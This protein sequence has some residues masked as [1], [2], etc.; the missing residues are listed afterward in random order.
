MFIIIA[1]ILIIVFV[2]LYTRNPRMNYG[3]YPSTLV[4]DDFEKMY[5]T[6]VVISPQSFYEQYFGHNIVKLKT[7]HTRIRENSK[8]VIWLAGDSS[9]DNKHWLF[10]NV[11]EKNILV[12][13]TLTPS[14]VYQHLFVPPI[15]LPDVAACINSLTEKNVALNC[16]LEESS[17]WDRSSKLPDTDRLIRH[18]IEPND[19]LI[20]SVGG[21]DVA[22]KLCLRTVFWMLVMWV[23]PFEWIPPYVYDLFHTQVRDYILKLTERNRPRKIIVCMFYYPCEMGEGWLDGS[24]VFRLYNRNREKMQRLIDLIFEKCTRKIKIPGSEVVPVHL[25]HVLDSRDEKDYVSRIEP[26]AQGGLKMATR[27]VEIIND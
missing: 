9:L 22:L 3:T 6:N 19:T 24:P 17:L 5:D 23:L 7:I 8:N 16:A 25:G 2:V 15:C 20:V 1:I 27:F 21:N 12:S 26:S 4:D 10:N 11:F 13:K 18:C 14:H